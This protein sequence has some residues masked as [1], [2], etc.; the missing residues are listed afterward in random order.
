MSRVIKIRLW[1]GV[2]MIPNESL[3]LMVKNIKNSG[4]GTL[5]QFTGIKDKNGVEVYEGDIVRYEYGHIGVVTWIDDMYA[6]SFDMSPVVAD[7]ECGGVKPDDI[8]VIGNIHQKPELQD[9]S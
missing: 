3:T 2:Q 4:N 9:A 8:E 7:Q 1:N 5:M 6:F